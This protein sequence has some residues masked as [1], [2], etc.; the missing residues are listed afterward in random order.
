MSS[1]RSRAT[2]ALG[3]E[4]M[5]EGAKEIRK[6]WAGNEAGVLVYFYCHFLV[7]NV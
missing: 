1:L 6:R 5:S 3:N 2:L 4:G 7:A